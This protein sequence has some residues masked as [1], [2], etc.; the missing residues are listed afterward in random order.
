MKNNKPVGNISKFPNKSMTGQH[1][2]MKETRSNIAK[3][4]E[5]VL[6]IPS[7]TLDLERRKS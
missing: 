7:V 2:Q 6:V 4:T 3:G 1:E 5:G